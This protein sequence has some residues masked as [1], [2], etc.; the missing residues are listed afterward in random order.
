MCLL[1]FV[2]LGAL[3][4][5]VSLEPGAGKGHARLESRPHHG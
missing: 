4:G 3:I 5:N 1:S 2:F